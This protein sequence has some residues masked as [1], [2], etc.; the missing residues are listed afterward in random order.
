LHRLFRDPN[1]FY[2]PPEASTLNHLPACYPSCQP[3]GWQIFLTHGFLF[4]YIV[5]LKGYIL[6]NHLQ[7]ENYATGH[8]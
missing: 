2:E 1:S 7:H 3:A 5:Y 6:K 8:L 4:R